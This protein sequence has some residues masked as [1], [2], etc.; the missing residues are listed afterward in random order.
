MSWWTNTLNAIQKEGGVVDTT[1]DFLSSPLGTVAT[2]ALAK[3]F[4]LLDAKTPVVGYQ[5]SIPKYEAVRERVPMQQDPNRRPGSGGRRYF[6]DV[7]YADRPE[8]Q[9][10]SV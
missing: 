2:S 4:G 6:S 8:R 9:P 10:M 7:M 5:G 1:L 3:E